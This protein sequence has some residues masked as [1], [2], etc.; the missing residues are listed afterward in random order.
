M[1]LKFPILRALKNLRA[2]SFILLTGIIIMISREKM[3]HRLGLVA[4]QFNISLKLHPNAN[5][6]MSCSVLRLGLFHGMSA[7]IMTWKKAVFQI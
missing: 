6:S 4:V 7:Y 2:K 1:F 3:L 5:S